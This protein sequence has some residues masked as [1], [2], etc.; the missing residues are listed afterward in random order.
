M[1]GIWSHGCAQVGELISFPQVSWI[2]EDKKGI[3]Q[4][5]P[6][7]LRLRMCSFAWGQFLFVQV[8]SS[9]RTPVQH[10]YNKS[11]CL[12]ELQRLPTRLLSSVRWSTDAT[13]ESLS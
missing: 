10:L 9:F 3:C 12:A 8:I 13:A 1:T 4:L 7:L 5:P 2:G 6:G 11:T